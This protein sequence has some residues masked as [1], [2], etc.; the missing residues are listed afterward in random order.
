M[1][2]NDIDFVHKR[3]DNIDSTKYDKNEIDYLNDQNL[4]LNNRKDRIYDRNSNFDYNKNIINNPLINFDP[5]YF[6]KNNN[7]STDGN[8]RN[9]DPYRN[10]L[11]KKGIIRK[12]D[13]IN[14]QTYYI[15]VDSSLR[16]I[17]PK[18][19]TLEPILLDS[20]PFTFESG[21]TNL[22]IKVPKN[23]N[24]SVGDKITISGLKYTKNKT[25]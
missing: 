11:Y 24:F 12:S 3:V 6:E 19:S 7:I 20:N 1:D 8:D 23:H 10:F 21:N 18:I 5:K 17:I 13:N 25:R 4:V 9:F 14:Y 15:N 16:R 22:N 2:E